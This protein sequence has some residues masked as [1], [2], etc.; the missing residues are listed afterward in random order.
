MG[1]MSTVT[2]EANAAVSFN[3]LVCQGSKMDGTAK[4]ILMQF[5]AELNAASSLISWMATVFQWVDG[6]LTTTLTIIG[7]VLCVLG[8]LHDDL[9]ISDLSLFVSLTIVNIA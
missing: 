5:S 7:V 3:K 2:L 6:A 4:K 8:F 9:G 1:K